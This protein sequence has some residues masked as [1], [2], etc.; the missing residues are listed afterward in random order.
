MVSALDSAR[1]GTLRAIVMVT[2]GVP[3]QCEGADDIPL[4]ADAV[5]SSS[6]AAASAPKQ[7]AAA[8]TVR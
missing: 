3:E 5:R 4:V 1:G 7:L 6:Q 2:G 8:V